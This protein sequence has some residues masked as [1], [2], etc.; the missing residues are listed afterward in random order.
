M[1]FD[2]RKELITFYS[3]KEQWK[4]Y[5]EWKKY[6]HKK[7]HILGFDLYEAVSMVSSRR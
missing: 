3:I 1:L 6:Y 2:I 5:A 4:Y 7:L